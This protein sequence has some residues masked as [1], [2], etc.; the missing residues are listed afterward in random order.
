MISRSNHNLL[1]L[2]EVAARSLP[3]RYKFTFK[4]HPGLQV[5]LTN[6]PGIQ[7]EQTSEKLDRILSKF[8]M[9]ISAN[10]TSAA[11]DAFLA[12]LPVIIGLDGSSF[13]LSPLRGQPSV[14]FVGTTEEMVLA[15][16]N[17]TS[18]KRE[19][20]EQNLFWLDEKLPR[21]HHLLATMGGQ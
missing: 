14:C 16:T 7:A 17:Q 11:V 18:F 12:G 3:N 19:S 8:D 21:W 13:N 5:D 6:Y 10:S 20:Q 4:P 15:L 2:L 9:A 1:S